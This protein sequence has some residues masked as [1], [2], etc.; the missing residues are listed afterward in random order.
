M[1]LDLILSSH[2]IGSYYAF[3]LQILEYCFLLG[4]AINCSLHL[5]D[6]QVHAVARLCPDQSPVS[7]NHGRYVDELCILYTVHCNSKTC[8]SVELL[9]TCQ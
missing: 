6:S 7:L 4:S 1:H 2:G 3:I 5:L 9:P 8:P